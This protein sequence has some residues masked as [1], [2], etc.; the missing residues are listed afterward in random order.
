MPPL[1]GPG[2]EIA[3][4][5]TAK[6]RQTNSIEKLQ[7]MHKEMLALADQAYALQCPLLGEQLRLAAHRATE[8][9]LLIDNS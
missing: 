7:Q 1:T 9:I 4:L 3:A 6:R 8:A 5:V 2:S